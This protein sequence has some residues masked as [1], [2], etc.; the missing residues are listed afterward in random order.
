M[1]TMMPVKILLWGTPPDNLEELAYM[2]DGGR[3]K[4]L[5]HQPISNIFPSQ[6]SLA[7]KFTSE[8]RMLDTLGHVRDS[9]DNKATHVS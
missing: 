7:E 2:K 9:I 3:N 1:E 4:S 5:H 8:P 6:V